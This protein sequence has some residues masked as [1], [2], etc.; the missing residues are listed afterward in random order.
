MSPVVTTAMMQEGDAHHMECLKEE[1]DFEKLTTL[2]SNW[3]HSKG[4]HHPL[5]PNSPFAGCFWPE[6]IDYSRIKGN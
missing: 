3:C 6:K 2:R 4:I 5:F 1:M